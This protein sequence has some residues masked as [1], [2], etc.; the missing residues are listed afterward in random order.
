[1]V[2][3]KRI[4]MII[5]GL[6]TWFMSILTFAIDL[7]PDNGSIFNTIQGVSFNFLGFITMIDGYFP[8]TEFIVV[9]GIVFAVSV[10]MIGIKITFG[11][12]NTMMKI[13]P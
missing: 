13:K 1:M 4:I 9:S 2:E 8:M 12:F 7:L 10:S 3:F 11:L 5:E 6:L